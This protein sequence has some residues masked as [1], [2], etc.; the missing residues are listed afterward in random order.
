[1]SI[2]LQEVFDNLVYGEFAALSM[3]EEGSINVKEYNRL[4]THVNLGV[5][6]LYKRFELKRMRYPLLLLMVLLF[7]LWVLPMKSLRF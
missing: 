1:M 4:I 2:T 7:M 3:A 5:G 6:E